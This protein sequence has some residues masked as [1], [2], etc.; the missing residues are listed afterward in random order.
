MAFVL[1]CVWLAAV[2]PA[3][4]AEPRHRIGILSLQPGE[5]A[6]LIPALLEELKTL[7]HDRAALG[8]DYRGAEGDGARLPALAQ[9]LAASAPDLIVVGFGTQ[10][11][12]A[13]KAAGGRIPIVFSEVGDPVGSGLVAS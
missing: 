7:A 3:P 8:V 6:T 5:D 12:Q 9:A 13:A 1:G 11:A 2:M 4:A 10:A